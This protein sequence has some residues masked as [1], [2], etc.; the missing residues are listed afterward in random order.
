MSITPKEF[1]RR[2]DEMAKLLKQIKP[3]SHALDDLVHD[4]KSQEASDINNNGHQDQL[5]YLVDTW[6]WKETN[7]AVREALDLPVTEVFIDSTDQH[8]KCHHCGASQL[9]PFPM[10][11]RAVAKWIDDWTKPHE[12]A[13]CLEASAGGGGSPSTGPSGS[14][15]PS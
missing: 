10:E 11:V 6:G 14:S 3:G 4:A 13:K 7:K 1:H 12:E 15:T 8:I 5:E 2:Q 9:C